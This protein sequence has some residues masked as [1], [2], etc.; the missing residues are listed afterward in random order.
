[1]NLENPKRLAVIL[2]TAILI[3]ALSFTLAW[4]APSDQET[5]S[6][7][8][9]RLK[10]KSTRKNPTPT[11][12][13]VRKS[14]PAPQPQEPTTPPE[15]GK[16]TRPSQAGDSTAIA[17]I[18]G[19]T[20]IGIGYTLYKCIDKLGRQCKNDSKEIRVDT[21]GEVQT[22]DMVYFTIEPNIDGFLYIF[23]AVNKDELKMIYPYY[24]IEEGDNKIQAHVLY[25]IGWFEFADKPEYANLS[26]ITENIYVIVTRKPLPK[27]PT[28][29]EL[30][31][32]CRS[33][34]AGGDCRWPLM[35]EQ[36]NLVQAGAGKSLMAGS[37]EEIGKAISAVESEA[38]NKK[39][40]IVYSAPEPSLVVMNE[41]AEQDTLLMKTQLVHVRR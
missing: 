40:D 14:P 33:L 32:I 8:G 15:G 22:G 41:S 3:S 36:F 17:D 1:M 12:A 31:K 20:P 7:R 28:G 23:N 25:K 27:V 11:P 34:P 19:R 13:T 30:V 18:T 35:R 37:R 24:R 29:G 5:D 9:I 39:R 21:N 26:R 2:G 4:Q 38:I 6:E 16:T 10:F